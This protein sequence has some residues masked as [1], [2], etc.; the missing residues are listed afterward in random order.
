M[1]L[2]VATLRPNPFPELGVGRISEW[3]EVVTKLRL[4]FAQL[5]KS[6][7]PTEYEIRPACPPVETN[8]IECSNALSCHRG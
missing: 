6:F 5:L 3:H 2:V 7:A 4:E 8:T 1:Q